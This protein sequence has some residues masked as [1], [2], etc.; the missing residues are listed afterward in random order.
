MMTVR[1]CARSHGEVVSPSEALQRTSNSLRLLRPSHEDGVHEAGARRRIWAAG[2]L[3]E[4]GPGARLR[5]SSARITVLR[6]P[7]TAKA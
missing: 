4:P 3:K 6:G 1:R 7:D 2:G 5:R